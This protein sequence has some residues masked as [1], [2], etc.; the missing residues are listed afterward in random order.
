MASEVGPTCSLYHVL[1]P[2]IVHDVNPPFTQFNLSLV[3]TLLSEKNSGPLKAIRRGTGSPAFWLSPVNT[4]LLL[5][6]AD[7]RGKIVLVLFRVR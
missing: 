6:A 7:H 5:R 1:V 4:F 2:V 3:V